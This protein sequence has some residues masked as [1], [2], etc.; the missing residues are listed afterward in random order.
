MRALMFR[1]IRTVAERLRASVVLAS[2]RSFARVRTLVDLQVLQPRKRLITTAKLLRAER[3]REGG[4][5][6]ET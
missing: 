2:V 6:K 3:E 5:G 4:K 1:P